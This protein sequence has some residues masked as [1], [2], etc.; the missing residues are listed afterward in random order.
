MLPDTRTY[1]AEPERSDVSRSYGLLKECNSVEV[2][3]GSRNAGTS[4]A[5]G[6]THDDE[7]KELK[8]KVAEEFETIRYLS[9]HWNLF[10]S[11]WELRVESWKEK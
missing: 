8:L 5:D 7:C 11:L 10:F 4:D 6:E 9:F 3:L 1:F 2:N